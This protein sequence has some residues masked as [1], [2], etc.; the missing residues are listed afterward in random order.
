MLCSH[1]HCRTTYLIDLYKIISC[2]F[3]LPHL[4]FTWWP[5]THQNQVLCLHPSTLYCFKLFLFACVFLFVWDVFLLL[6]LFCCCCYLFVCLFFNH[7][8]LEMFPP[9]PYRLGIS[10]SKA[11]GLDAKAIE[12]SVLD[13]EQDFTHKHTAVLKSI[14]TFLYRVRNRSFLSWE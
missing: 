7:I 13:Q 8:A 10:L 4:L 5:M 11:I 9:P 1:M 6:L 3:L 2:V 14:I 12:K